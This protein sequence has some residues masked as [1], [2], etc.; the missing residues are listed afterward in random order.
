MAV[1]LEL[2]IS[3][4][5]AGR[6]QEGRQLLNLLIQQN[7][8]DEKAWLWMSSVVETDEQRARCLYH[9]LSINPT[10]QLARKGLQVLGIVVSD[11]RPVQ[12]PRDSQPIHIARPAAASNGNGQRG[13]FLINAQT[14]TQDL[15]FTPLTPPAPVVQASPAILA[16]KVDDD[17]AEPVAPVVE[18]AAPPPLPPAVEPEPAV[19]NPE[20]EAAY[21]VVY[22]PLETQPLTPPPAEAAPPELAPAPLAAA[23]L[24][25]PASV[26]TQ[27]LPPLPQNP[28]PAPANHNGTSLT[29]TSRLPQIYTPPSSTAPKPDSQPFKPTPAPVQNGNSSPPPPSET[30]RS[31][32]I[33]VN[34]P[35]PNAAMPYFYN[36]PPLNQADPAMLGYN[37]QYGPRPDGQFSGLHSAATINMPLPPQYPR[38]PAEQMPVMQTPLGLMPYT[39]QYPYHASATILMPTMSEAEARARLSASQAIPTASAAAMPLQN[40]GGWPGMPAPAYYAEEE[41]DTAEEPSDEVNILAVIIF[42]TLSL[43]ALGGLGML[44]LLILTAPA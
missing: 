38:S 16:L 23:P 4:I 6:K 18:A 24:P 2:A 20:P 41:T 37:P 1:S 30:R 44:V 10:S 39:G 17:D 7:P 40:M 3:A 32:P 21:E 27:V 11:S 13:P 15:P 8:N 9:V 34:Y 25:E 28:P 14:I 22:P 12:I 31:Q 26:Q 43:T 5:K 42:G 35:D 36:Q 19:E 29:D 33:L